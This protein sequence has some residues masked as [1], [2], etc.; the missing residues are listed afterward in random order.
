M[1]ISD[2]LIRITR[3]FCF[4]LLLA[5]IGCQTVVPAGM[6]TNIATMNYGPL[7]IKTG[8]VENG[9]AVDAA[10]P[11]SPDANELFDERIENLTPFYLFPELRTEPTVWGPLLDGFNLELKEVGADKVDVWF[12]FEGRYPGYCAHIISSSG[13]VLRFADIQTSTMALR[14]NSYSDVEMRKIIS[15][16]RADCEKRTAGVEELLLFPRNCHIFVDTLDLPRAT[17]GCYCFDQNLAIPARAARLFLTD[18]QSLFV[19]S[20]SGQDV[21]VQI[22][23]LGQ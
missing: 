23:E 10:N 9:R 11:F 15:R 8:C 3:R 22:F 4:V 6:A 7:Q 2:R 12:E 21:I 19:I 20:I 14:P 18:G 13:P 5:L 16:Q 1:T 17:E